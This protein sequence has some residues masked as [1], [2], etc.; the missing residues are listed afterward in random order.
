MEALPPKRVVA[1]ALLAGVTILVHLDARRDGVVVPERLRT[2]PQLVLRIGYGLVPPIP[3]LKVD[4]EGIGCTLSFN[5]APFWCFLPWTAVY[6]LVGEDGRAMFW[7]EDVPLELAQVPRPNAEPARPTPKRA[8]KP[9]LRAAD[10]KPDGATD[11]AEAPPP[12]PAAGK[13]RALP[14]YLRVVK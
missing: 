2:G 3:D 6:G 14:P 1:D 5:R 8:K 13:K 12:E 11:A 4:D 9:R 7:P 10:A